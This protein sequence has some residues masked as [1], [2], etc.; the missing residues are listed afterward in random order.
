MF[1]PTSTTTETMLMRRGTPADAPQIAVLA[2]LEDR[3]LPA[4]PFLV[5]ELSGTVAAAIS[6]S[7]GTVVADPFRP[8][9][10][11]VAMLRL[12]AAQI[13]GAGELAARRAQRAPQPFAAAA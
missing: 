12:R 5:A 10:D 7:S 9:S 1:H 8:T 11:A 13:R 6:L 3:R 2:R 4:G